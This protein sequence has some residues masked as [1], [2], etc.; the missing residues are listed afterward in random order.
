MRGRRNLWAI[1]ATLTAVAVV[2]VVCGGGGSGDDGS[3]GGSGTETGGGKPVE[4]GSVSY[5]I[6]A[7]NPGGWCL[8]E[9]QLDIAGIQVARTDLRH[10]DHPE[11]E[12]RLRRHASPS[13]YEASPDQTT[14]TFTCARA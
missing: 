1:A 14:F 3:S 9:A 5:A 11:R 10:P 4:G 8:P 6:E 2:A 12:R 7:E 13:R